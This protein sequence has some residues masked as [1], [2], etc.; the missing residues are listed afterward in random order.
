MKEKR[1]EYYLFIHDI[2]AIITDTF[3]K[4]GHTTKS[5]KQEALFAIQEIT[6]LSYGS[7]KNII[8]KTKKTTTQKN[9]KY[10]TNILPRIQ[11]IAKI[12][13]QTIS[14]YHQK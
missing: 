13:N 6:G 14:Y 12:L 1:T 5:A 11:Y 4:Q 7:V 10:K 3:Q 8:S 2:Y 9:T